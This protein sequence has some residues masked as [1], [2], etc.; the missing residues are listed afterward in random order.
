ME[1]NGYYFGLG[2]RKTSTAR[3]FMKSGKGKIEINKREISNYFPPHD[4]NYRQTILQPLKVLSKENDYDLMINVR[5]GGFTGQLEA[6]RLGVTRA[7]LQI[8]PEYKTTLKAFKL[9]TRPFDKKERKHYGLRAARK[10][11][12]FS[13]R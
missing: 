12:Q 7:I 13:K 9:L 5:G 4:S 3:V 1:I 2:R 11:P 10:A 8:S 6:I